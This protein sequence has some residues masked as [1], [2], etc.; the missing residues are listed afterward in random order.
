MAFPIRR[1]F[2]SALLVLFAACALGGC[3]PKAKDEPAACA[4]S[5]TDG[6]GSDG[7]ARIFDPDPLSSSGNPGVS[8]T[9]LS[10]DN[11]RVPVT[12]ANLT[13]H[14]VLEGKYVRSLNEKS[15][16]VEGYGA[17]DEKNQFSYSHADQRFQ[18]AMAYSFGDRYRA[19]LDSLGYL[20][21]IDAVSIWAI[22]DVADNAFYSPTARAACLGYS[23]DT[24]GAYYADDGVVTV[25][26]LQHATTGSLYSVDDPSL[27]LNPLWV[28]EGGALNEGVS[29][30]MG[31][32]FTESLVAPGIDRKVFG[33]WALKLFDAHSDGSRGAH[34]CPAYDSDY[35][36]CAN[37]PGFSAQDNTVSYVYPDGLGWSYGLNRS[38]PQYARQ[39]FLNSLHPEEIHNAGVLI[40]GALWD[41]YEAVSAA[42]GDAEVSRAKV[43]SLV[44]ESL[45]ALPKPTASELAPVTFISFADALVQRS[46]LA[47]LGFS[48]SERQAVRDALAL[49][50]LQP[51]G[52]QLVPA[53]W[54]EVGP[55]AQG[56]GLKILDNPGKLI[57]WTM[58]MFGTYRD[59]GFIPQST[60]TGLNGAL[61]PGEVVVVWFDLRNVS[62]ITAGSVQVSVTIPDAD[63]DAIEIH[64]NLNIGIQTLQTAQTVYAKVNGTQIRDW[65][66]TVDGAHASYVVPTDN[67]FF[68]TQPYYDQI[69]W[70]GIW[71]RVKPGTSG[72]TVHF[73]VQ[74]K[75][76]NGAAATLTFPARIN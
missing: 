56:N 63:K 30:F 60:S 48:A 17:F 41:V 11:Y 55:G 19:Y 47:A 15:C 71:L 46:S 53:N 43:A 31:L 26:E 32:L 29:D 33:R 28:G 9:S 34:R 73:E 4:V 18:E 6:A 8:P 27:D 40:Q 62:A 21:P 72:R 20:H 52:A 69:W 51:S 37:Y 39:T 23:T 49:R 5:S 67:T 1:P 70:T 64:P 24:P 35:P 36:R 65:L 13:G 54:A 12:L 25:H 58:R 57:D 16:G 59:P 22:C 66:T 44:M 74:A 10:L 61:D 50:G 45:R 7:A 75:P 76:S 42:N 38:G 2:H 14:G 3:K 68:L